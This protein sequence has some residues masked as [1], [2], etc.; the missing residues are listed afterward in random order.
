MERQALARHLARLR[1]TSGDALRRHSML[2]AYPYAHTGAGSSFLTTRQQDPPDD[3]TDEACEHRLTVS[4]LFYL[5][6][7]C[8]P[9]ELSQRQ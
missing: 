6:E 5:V 8:W 4:G 3:E 2:S 9:T 7:T 1:V